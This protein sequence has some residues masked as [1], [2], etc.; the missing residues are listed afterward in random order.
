MADKT[1]KFLL[2]GEDKSASKTLKG[3]GD[4]AKNTGGKLDGMKVAAGAAL[5]G[6]GAA[7]VDFG[8]KSVSAFRDAEQSQRQ[9]EDA[10]KRFPS[11]ADVS[12]EKLRELNTGIQKKTGADADDLASSQAVM[13]QYGLTGQQIADLTPLLDDYAVKTGK[14]LP[15]AAE[16]LGKAMLGQGRALK[17]VGIDFKDTGSV[18]GNFEQVMGGLRSQVGGFAE[19]EAGSA[20]GQ[21]RKLQTEFGDVQEEVGS[22]LLPV[23]VELGGVLL[24]VIDFVQRNSDVLIPL[25]AVLG[26][27]A[28]GVMAWN[29]IQAIL[30]ITLA[31]NPI[32]IVVI[33]IAA[34]VA[35]FVTAYNTS[36]TFRTVVDSA[37]N[38]VKQTGQDVAN[39]FTDTLPTFFSRSA[40]AIGSAF[41]KVKDFIL[42]PIRSAVAWINDTFVSGINGFL[43]TIGVSWVVPTIPGFADGGYTGPGGK[44]QPAGV[45]HAG[46]VVWSQRDVAAWGGPQAVDNMR[47]NPPRGYA[48]GGIVG[49]FISGLVGGMPG[50]PSPWGEVLS[51][52]LGKVTGGLVDKIGTFLAELF[53]AGSANGLPVAGTI[54]SPY[55]YRINPITGASELH[56][57]VDIA[58]PAGSPVAAPLAGTVTFAGWNGGYGNQVTLNHGG[59]TTFYAHMSSILA[60]VGQLLQAGQ[61]LGL[62]GSTG[63]STGPHLHWGSSAGDPMQMLYDRGGWLP[64]GVNLTRNGTG[65]P[66]AVLTA[67]QWSDISTLASGGA[68]N[69]LHPDDLRELANILDR[70]PVRVEVDGR[71]LAASVRNHN[72][73]IR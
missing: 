44:H 11:V 31:A 16:D 12:I 40:E 38:L 4:E 52:I 34:L 65:Q 29:A 72:R 59:F 39:W 10:Y 55:G 49:D 27:V 9:L 58:A 25:A 45:V 71:Q 73:S 30:N 32:G 2:V 61:V 66:E 8:A 35:A 19:G 1:I 48:D 60:S 23:L 70:R 28:A 15:S 47:R 51:V 56:D 22:K 41:G 67:E 5:V 42:E 18:A 43:G 20:E 24:G 53:G 21:L 33:A 63:M 37:L 36:E 50:I 3:V 62:V 14:D 69:R 13:A 17:D 54:S 46:E 7:I 64:S 26:T 6:A 57:G 68:Q